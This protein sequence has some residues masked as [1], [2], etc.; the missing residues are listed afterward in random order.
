MEERADGRLAELRESPQSILKID[1]TFSLRRSSCCALWNSHARNFQL[2]HC[3]RD[4]IS[5]VLSNPISPS[6]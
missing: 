4:G 5:G 3:L 2:D 6:P 1:P